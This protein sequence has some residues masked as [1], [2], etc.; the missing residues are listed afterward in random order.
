M[1][2]R[3]ETAAFALVFAAVFLS[4][5]GCG[6]SSNPA[7]APDASGGDASADTGTVDAG[8]EAAAETGVDAGPD[9]G[10]SPP[11]GKQLVMSPN[12]LVVLGTT[13]DAN[14][15]YEDLTTQLIYAVPVAGG[16]P[17]K[18]GSMTSQ[19]RTL[20]TNGGTA[21]LYLPVATNPMDAVAPLSAWTAAGG[22][23]VIS[24]AALAQDSYFYTYDASQ[25]GKYVAYFATTDGVSGTLT[26]ST[27]DGLTQTPL[28]MNVDLQNQTCYPMVQFVGDT[29]VAQYCL[30]PEPPTV[31]STVSTFAAPTF[32]AVTIGAMFVPSN[33]PIAVDPTGKL[34]MLSPP[35]GGIALF[36]IDGTAPTTI[37]AT[38]VGAAFTPTGDVLYTSSSTAMLRWS[39]TTK[40]ATML[41]PSGLS[42]PLYLSA[43][44]NWV[45]AAAN[46]D[47]TTGLTDLYIASTMTPGPAISVVTTPTV[48]AFGFSA[49]SKY[50]GLGTNF[51]M[52]F[53]S[54]TFDFEVSKT[55]GG[56]PAKVLSAASAPLYTSGSKLICNT[57]QSKTTGAADI[58][59]LD[60]STTAAPT[61]LVTQADPDLFMAKTHDVVYSWYCDLNA[62]AGI[63]AL[64]P[65]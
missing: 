58:V 25:D 63:W 64:T 30:T 55:S 10:A 57:N 23:H 46:Q 3:I 44:A 24:T 34:L 47:S 16:S 60:L 42:F 39:A 40:M 27:I 65:P 56:M 51:P 61:V 32:T 4:V 26:A 37:D 1:H 14:A 31:V 2:R 38:G 50:S 11:M 7:S 22:V 19:G 9:C 28:V 21:V 33:S 62:M 52:N 13:G 41:V 43:D 36:P 49:D 12:P 54:A 6:S 8:G 35:T 29:L 5:Q 17:T 18:I 45:Q 48:S 20:W 53:G 59:A 15:I